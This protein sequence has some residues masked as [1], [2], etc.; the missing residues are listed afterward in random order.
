MLSHRNNATFQPFSSESERLVSGY[1]TYTK[2]LAFYNT[3][4][5]LIEYLATTYNDQG[6]NLTF[7]VADT[8]SL[9]Q[10]VDMQIRSWVPTGYSHP[11]GKYICVLLL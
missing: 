11:F 10:K 4:K 2:D 1:L 6:S 3:D 8:E 9:V 7:S 5:R